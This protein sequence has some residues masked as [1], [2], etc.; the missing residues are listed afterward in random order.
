M[1]ISPNIDLILF[2]II[3][4]IPNSTM[5][6]SCS[7]PNPRNKGTL[8]FKGKDID[9]FFSK[10]KDYAD[11]ARLTEIQRCEF[12]HLYFSKKE[13]QVLD[14]LEEFQ[15]HDWDKLKEELWSLYASSCASGSVSPLRERYE[16]K[17][18]REVRNKLAGHEG[19]DNSQVSG[20]QL[21]AASEFRLSASQ[22]DMCRE[23]LH[24]I[25]DCTETRFLRFLGIC[26]LDA[27]G[28]VVMRDGSAL[29]PAEGEGGAARVIREREAVATELD[30]FPSKE[31]TEPEVLTS[32]TSDYADSSDYGYSITYNYMRDVNEFED[33]V[34]VKETEEGHQHCRRHQ[35][36]DELKSL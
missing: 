26:D 7:M 34:S 14:I 27:S 15:C 1:S 16:S 28:R 12:L 29:P 5:A 19:V 31:D 33:S 25:R 22:C 32:G 13:R 23:L 11:R 4:S 8:H 21:H 36:G 35:L 9:I 2:E 30:V 3:T 10:Y 18:D 20:S 6:D 24:D 17:C